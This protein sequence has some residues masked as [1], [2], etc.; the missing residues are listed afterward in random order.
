MQGPRGKSSLVS[1]NQ[2]DFMSGRTMAAENR[3]RFPGN[4][5]SQGEGCS[6][7]RLARAGRGDHA[8]GLWP[9]F[10]GPLGESEP[11][12]AGLAEARLGVLSPLQQYAWSF[13]PSD[14]GW[15]VP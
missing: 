13:L 15:H 5:L 14:G 6:E 9:S 8:A 11:D 12:A 4:F 3:S 2:M 7:D 10:P 1:H